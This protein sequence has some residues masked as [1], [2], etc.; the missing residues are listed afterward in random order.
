M[1]PVINFEGA[2]GCGKSYAL[3]HLKKYY[4]INNI[5]VTYVKSVPY[6]DFINAH[7]KEWYDMTNDNIRYMEYLAYEV[8]NYY[9]NILPNLGTSVILIDRYLPSCYAYNSQTNLDSTY[10]GVLS[11]VMDTLCANFFK[12]NV[13]F[14][15]DVTDDVLIER[16][17]VFRQHEELPNLDFVDKLRKKYLEFKQIYG[18]WNIHFVNGNQPIESIIIEMLGYIEGVKYDSTCL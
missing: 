9:K 1:F 14:I 4:E 12:P 7:S 8:N 3:E 18:N 17:K 13:T 16:F 2:D 15:F 10:K 6:H 11:K 5:P